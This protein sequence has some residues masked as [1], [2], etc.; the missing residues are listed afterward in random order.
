LDSLTHILIGAAIG[1]KIAGEKIGRKAAIVGAIAKTF[2][3]FDVFF[4]GINNPKQYLCVHRG[5]SHSLPVQALISLPLAYLCF[6]IFKEK[7]SFKMWYF[8]WIVCMWG[9]S[10]LDTC[11]N[12]GT[13]LLLP[14]N[15]IPYSINTMAIADLFFTLPLLIL[16]I[17]ALIFKNNSLGRTRTITYFLAYTT[18]YLGATFINKSIVNYKFEKI[19]KQQNV[20]HQNTLTNPTILNNILWYGIACND[21]TISVGECCKKRTPFSFIPIHATCTC[22]IASNT[23]PIYL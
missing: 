21:S 19:C 15:K 20:P 7:L 17:V 9:H 3:D 23:P 18:L 4:S 8:L 6:K 13:R 11:T 2:P 14:F 22:S 12:Y 16:L 10:L 5:Y 1:D